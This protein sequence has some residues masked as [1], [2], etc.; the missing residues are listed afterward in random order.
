MENA[1][2]SDDSNTLEF[3][4][5]RLGTSIRSRRHDLGLTQEELAWRASLHR[6][7][8]AD[9]ERGVRNVT[10]RTVGQLAHA[11]DVSVADLLA[12]VGLP[13]PPPSANARIGEVL[14]VEDNPADVELTLHACRESKLCNPVRVVRDG[15]AALEHLFGVPGGREREAPVPNLILLDLHLPKVSGLEVLR[16]VRGDPSTRSVPVTVLTVSQSERDMA[17][18]R[19][20]GV[21]HYLVKPVSAAEL[22]A[23]VVASCQGWAVTTPALSEIACG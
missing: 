23:M 18:C 13:V 8:I 11:L 3:L 14:L 1:P 20:L 4:K 2:P 12:G 10:L 21:E 5:A 19:E 15:A 9:V 22:G 16:R 7:Y 6:T 17:E